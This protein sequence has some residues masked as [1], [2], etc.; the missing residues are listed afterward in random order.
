MVQLYVYR[1]SSYKKWW[2]VRKIVGTRSTNFHFSVSSR[3]PVQYGLGIESYNVRIRTQIY[4]RYT[5][6]LEIHT[7]RT[8]VRSV[9][10]RRKFLY[11]AACVDTLNKIYMF[12]IRMCETIYV[13]Q[14]IL[15]KQRP[16]GVVQLPYKKATTY[17]PNKFCEKL[18]TLSYSLLVLV[19]CCT[20]HSTR[21]R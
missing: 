19:R 1:N 17:I 7:V 4:S 8:S 6:A 14:R 3:H 16:R 21:L 15:P 5:N 10:S 9:G 11:I 18:A 20:W 12:G 13:Y 2:K